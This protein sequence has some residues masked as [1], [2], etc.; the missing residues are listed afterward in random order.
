MVLILIG[1]LSIFAGQTLAN[2]NY[3]TTCIPQSEVTKLRAYRDSCKNGSISVP[4][5]DGKQVNLNNSCVQDLPNGNVSICD[6]K[7]FNVQ[8][9]YDKTP[10]DLMCDIQYL[11]YLV[12]ELAKY[13]PDEFMGC[14]Q[15]LAGKT[16]N[17]FLSLFVKPEYVRPMLK[18]AYFNSVLGACP[19]LVTEAGELSPYQY[20]KNDKS[21]FDICDKIHPSTTWCPECRCTFKSDQCSIATWNRYLKTPNKCTCYWNYLKLSSESSSLLDQ[22]LASVEQQVISNMTESISSNPNFNNCQSSLDNFFNNPGSSTSEIESSL[23]AAVAVCPTGMLPI[24]SAGIKYCSKKSMEILPKINAIESEIMTLL[25]DYLKSSYPSLV[26]LPKCTLL[27]SQK[28]ESGNQS[29]DISN[30]LIVDKTFYGTVSNWPKIVVNL[31]PPVGPDGKPSAFPNSQNLSQKFADAVNAAVKNCPFT[32]VNQQGSDFVE[33]LVSLMVGAPLM[34]IANHIFIFIGRNLL[35]RFGSKVALSNFNPFKTGGLYNNWKNSFTRR[36]IMP[37][38]DSPPGDPP[39]NLFDDPPPGSTPDELVGVGEDAAVNS[40]DSGA[41]AV[42]GVPTDISSQMAGAVGEGA[43]DAA[44]D[45]GVDVGA[46]IAADATIAAATGPIG[47][48]IMVASIAGAGLQMACNAA[49]GAMHNTTHNAQV[50]GSVF[51]DLIS[52]LSFALN[53]LTDV[54]VKKTEIALQKDLNHMVDSFQSQMMVDIAAIT[55]ALA[56]P[57]PNE[58]GIGIA[59][60]WGMD[61]YDAALGIGALFNLIGSVFSGML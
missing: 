42:A 16:L 22:S 4:G 19:D 2:N 35:T 23:N 52:P 58:I 18:A 43:T 46:N 27:K 25:Y 59:L 55:P 54:I 29:V 37:Q 40:A 3:N 51:C 34:M 41:S 5:P 9:A 31:S 32:V 50:A 11:N 7:C 24:A 44:V 6:Q 45:A 56:Y 48:V 10:L 53:E 20:I 61:L 8:M 14:M 12:T 49:L 39:G 21:S 60:D 13:T 28:D 36:G 38:D 26:E 17:G 33:H 57:A 47:A 30:S 15:G 1:L